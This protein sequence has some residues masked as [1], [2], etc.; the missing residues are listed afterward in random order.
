[1]V[2]DPEKPVSP[3]EL[4][5]HMFEQLGDRLDKLVKRSR[6]IGVTSSFYLQSGRLSHQHDADNPEFAASLAK[7]PLSV[8]LA[9]RLQDPTEELTVYPDVIDAT[10]GGEYDKPRADAFVVT[11]HDLLADMLENSGNTAYRIFSRMHGVDTINDFYGEMGW[12]VSKVVA[13]E[14]DNEKI[15]IGPTTAYEATQQLD[16]LMTDTSW[17]GQLAR[18]RLSGKNAARYG[19]Q[20]V[21]Y[22]RGGGV[23]IAS[24]TGEYTCAPDEPDRD[25]RSYRNEVVK[26][27]GDSDLSMAILTSADRRTRGYLSAQVVTHFGIEILSALGVSPTVSLGRRALL[28]LT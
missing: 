17:I 5:A 21:A 22:R 1:M 20:S 10:G 27:L 4:D 9:R 18:E 24:K 3:N 13:N 6:M 2:F 7:V 28:A 11:A 25:D 12:P 26:S 15:D 8:L 19:I 23:T 16:A 14:K